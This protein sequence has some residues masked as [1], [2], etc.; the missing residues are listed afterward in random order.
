MDIAGAYLLVAD[1]VEDLHDTADLYVLDVELLVVDMAEDL[2][3]SLV[4]NL[5]LHVVDM[6]FASVDSLVADVVE[7]LHDT[8]NLCV[9]DVDLLV[10]FMFEDIV[11]AGCD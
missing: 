5:S 11:V 8:T 9:L 2:H 4:K 3:V 1:V 7:D 10:D 6:D